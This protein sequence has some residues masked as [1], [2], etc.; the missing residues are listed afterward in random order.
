MTQY[1]ILTDLNRCVGCL[2]CSVACKVVNGVEIGSFWNKVL[3]IGPFPDSEGAQFP[4]VYTYFLP[5]TCQH[6]ENPACVKVCPTGASQKLADGTVQID[7]EKCIGCQ[8]CAMACPYGVR[9]LNETERVVEKCTLC[10]QKIAQGEL[11]QCVAQCGARAR[12]FGDL[13]QGLDSFVGAGK[14]SIAGDAGYDAV[15]SE[16]CTYGD[17]AKPYTDSDVHHLPNVGNDPSFLYILR[18][19][20]WKGEE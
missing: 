19:H 1:A 4:D 10:E 20:E 11:P 13:E 9:Y 8:F 14:V 18:N 7:K 15:L 5:V 3:R 12:Y 16:F 6:C 17:I 2:G